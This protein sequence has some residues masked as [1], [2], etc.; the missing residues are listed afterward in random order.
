MNFSLAGSSSEF[1]RELPLGQHM[2]SAFGAL[3]D[4]LTPST[5]CPQTALDNFERV[6]LPLALGSPSPT[7]ARPPWLA[8][9]RG[10]L[11]AP[12]PRRSLAQG[13]KQIVRPPTRE[14]RQT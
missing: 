12:R 9:R 10:A 1:F 3:F 5:L 11:P 4:G 13:C 2:S 8:S 14:R 7:A 6:E